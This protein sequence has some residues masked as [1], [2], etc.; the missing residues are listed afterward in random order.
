MFFIIFI[1]FLNIFSS[2]DTFRNKFYYLSQLSKSKAFHSECF[3]LRDD[4]F[5]LYQSF[6]E[7]NKTSSFFSRIQMY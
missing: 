6:K 7:E 1:F 3:A 4:D 2:D 5:H